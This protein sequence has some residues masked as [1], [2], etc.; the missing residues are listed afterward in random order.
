MLQATNDLSSLKESGVL[1]DDECIHEKDA[2]LGVL[3]KL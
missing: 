3:R 2:V 1:T